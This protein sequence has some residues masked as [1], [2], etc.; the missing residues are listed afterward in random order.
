MKHSVYDLMHSLEGD[1]ITHLGALESLSELTKREE[2]DN[3]LPALFDVLANSAYRLVETSQWNR[4]MVK[5]GKVTL[6]DETPPASN[7][8][9]HP[10]ISHEA[11]KT[12]TRDAETASDSEAPRLEVSHD[13]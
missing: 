7:E 12:S 9:Q 10:D 1:I 4:E 5:K 3:T 13:A 8:S 2:G 11:T 6:D